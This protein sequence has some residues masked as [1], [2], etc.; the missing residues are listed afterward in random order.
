MISCYFISLLFTFCP[1]PSIK[2]VEPPVYYFTHYDLWDISQTDWAPCTW[3]SWKDLCDLARK[4]I[5]T[6][7]LTSDI[8]S[9]MWI[10][11]WDK[12]M[13][14]WDKWCT[15]TYYVHDEMAKRFRTWCIK[16]PGT[17]YC[18]KWD[19]PWKEWWACYVKKIS[20]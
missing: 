16:R 19:L 2:K 13:L 18:I 20:N 6:M 15:W 12:V 5:H 7:A 9:K 4:W 10:K 3:A 14:L 1:T 17:N 11:W 8:R